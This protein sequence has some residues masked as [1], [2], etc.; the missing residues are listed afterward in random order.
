VTSV[1]QV[2]LGVLFYFDYLDSHHPN[3]HDT[4]V[5]LFDSDVMRAED[6][7]L[8][9]AIITHAVCHRRQVCH[10]VYSKGLTDVVCSSIARCWSVLRL[11]I[12][13]YLLYEFCTVVEVLQQQLIHPQEEL[14]I[15]PGVGCL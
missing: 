15:Q 13:G 10:K 1:G 11:S 6:W 5:D 4:A 12:P 2:A 9:A 8:F 3:Q 7:L 14:R